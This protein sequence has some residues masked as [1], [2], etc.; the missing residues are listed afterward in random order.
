MACH[1]LDFLD[2]VLGP[3]Q[4]ARGLSANQAG[5][6][7]AEDTVA[8]AFRFASGVEGTGLWW[9]TSGTDV[10]RTEILGTRG[11]VAFSSF[12]ESPVELSVGGEVQAFPIPN[13]RHVQQPLIQ[14]V[15]DALTGKG[16]CPSTGET[17][18]RTTWVM[19]QIL[20]AHP[21]G[22]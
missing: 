19:E 20:A 13:P 16:A 4:A 1:T 12:D 21:D 9:F 7:A 18:L 3:I 11:R 14:S 2:F 6:Y 15:V 8:A 10:D 5:L 17:A 22:R